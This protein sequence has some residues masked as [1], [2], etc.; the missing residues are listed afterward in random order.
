MNREGHGL[1]WKVISRNK[2]RVKLDFGTL[3]EAMSGF[4]H[5]TGQEDGPP[6][7]PPFGLADGVAGISGALAV[8][9]ALHH[10]DA[11]GGTGQVIELSLLEPLLGILGPGPTV[12]DQLGIIAGRHGNRSPNDAPATGTSPATAAGSQSRPARSRSPSG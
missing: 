5:Q 11:G 3:M 6:T 9:I 7:L 8:M 2:R 10:R 4:D 1:W 12:Y